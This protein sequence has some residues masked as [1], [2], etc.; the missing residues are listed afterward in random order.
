MRVST[1]QEAIN[2]NDNNSV[3]T[4]LRLKQVLNGY[5]F[6]GGG[7]GSTS[8]VTEA[9]VNAKINNATNDLRYHH[10]VDG[11]RL[12][13][14]GVNGSDTN[15]G[16]ESKPFKT[17][18]RFFEEAEKVKGGRS[19]IRCYIVSAGE[20]VINKHSFSHISMH[21]TGNVSGVV[22]KFTTDRDVKFYQCHCNFNNITIEAPNATEVAFDGSNASITNCTINQMVRIF[23]GGGSFSGCTFRNFKGYY[24]NIEFKS[25]IGVTN[26]S[27][28][29][30]AF[31]FNNCVVRMA[32]EVSLANLI[33]SGSGVNCYLYC[34]NTF[35]TLQNTMPS[36]TRKYNYGFYG[37]GNVV[38]T[39]SNYYDAIKN[40]A[41]SGIKMSNTPTLFLLTDDNLVIDSLVSEESDP[42]VPSWVKSI[43]QAD[44]AKWNSNSVDCKVI[45]SPTEPTTGEEVWFQISR[46]LFIPNVVK[47]GSVIKEN[48]SLEYKA[49]DK[50][51]ITDYIEVKPN[52]VYTFG[53]L[54]YGT[55]GYNAWYD[56]NK[57]LI[58]TFPLP[59]GY[60]ITTTSP[61]NAAYIR[62]SL[63]DDP[64]GFGSDLDSFQFVTGDT[65]PEYT[66]HFEGYRIYVYDNAGN[67]IKIYDSEDVPEIEETDPT[68]PS[69][70]KA[71][72]EDQIAKWDSGT[73]GGSGDYTLPIATSDTLGGV[74]VGDNLTIDENG[75]LS[76]VAGESGGTLDPVPIDS[77]FDYDGDTVPDGYEQIDNVPVVDNVI[78]RN[79][80][81][82]PYTEDNK[83]KFTA[84][85]D[86]HYTHIG[87][88]ANL[89]AGKIYTLS[90]ETDAEVWGY[91]GD[92]ELYVCYNN[93]YDEYYGASGNMPFVFQP[94]NTGKYYIRV[95]VNKA[96][97]THSFW[98]FQIEEGNEATEFVPYLNL[99]EAMKPNAIYS[100]EERVVG[101]YLGKPL[102]RKTFELGALGSSSRTVDYTLTGNFERIVHHDAYLYCASGTNSLPAYFENGNF[103]FVNIYTS[104]G[105]VV[106]STYRSAVNV[107][108]GWRVVVTLE[109]T[110][111]N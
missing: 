110:K 9:E 37:A 84:L 89:E 86:D 106:V 39:K 43:T 17:I 81:Y 68:V 6:P 71:I 2:G 109:Y 32:G 42:T 56:S 83:F 25:S 49:N 5:S 107:W 74:I 11:V 38:I 75:R 27:P 87:Y 96:G 44:I 92:A 104:S 64:N 29:T 91:T 65:L 16:S 50:Y 67:Y 59:N 12:Y 90:A 94:K 26:T 102:Y 80:L 85:K 54:V 88:Y 15:D 63:Y 14:D 8:G 60:E 97:E 40:N 48:G 58:S 72:T 79:L 55:S 73:G 103:M 78:S 33:A 52:T 10:I 21:I 24:S 19:D 111:T 41:G 34:N 100:T 3:I 20:Y 105:S 7:G 22:L 36:N 35:L 45:V 4:P 82:T 13:I 61:D 51:I 18:T 1:A 31:Y 70:V 57:N 23:S 30:D 47:R 76:A 28:S 93:K 53:N 101:T 77:I 66:P 98:N 69:W 46:N 99:E 108:S 95:D 62:F